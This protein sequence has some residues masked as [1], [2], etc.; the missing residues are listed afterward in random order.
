[1]SSA[2][3]LPPPQSVQRDTNLITMAPKLEITDVFFISL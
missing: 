2:N 1:M 3:P